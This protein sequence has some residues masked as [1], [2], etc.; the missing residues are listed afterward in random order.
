MRLKS[1]ISRASVLLVIFAL[2]ACKHP[3]AIEGEGD[4]VDLNGSG[5]GCTLEQFQAQDGACKRNEVRGEYI[6]TYR[7]EPRP[8]WRLF[9][10]TDPAARL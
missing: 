6:V 1:S 3:L 10:G 7:A 9:A 4:I 5:H 8:G 2:Q